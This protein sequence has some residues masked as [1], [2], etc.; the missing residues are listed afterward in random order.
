[1]HILVVLFEKLFLFIFKSDIAKKILIIIIIGVFVLWIIGKIFKLI[2]FIFRLFIPDKP[3]EQP[4]IKVTPRPAPKIS[5]PVEREPDDL[6]IGIDRAFEDMGLNIRY[7]H[8]N[9]GAQ[10]MLKKAWAV[11]R[12]P[13]EVAENVRPEGRDLEPSLEHQVVRES[14]SPRPIALD[15]TLHVA[16]CTSHSPIQQWVVFNEIFSPPLA[17]REE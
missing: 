6:R 3:K 17:L 8:F 14:A 7:G 5:A 9:K 16:R 15:S 2:G 1:M 10:N 11:R 12:T 13:A 4:V